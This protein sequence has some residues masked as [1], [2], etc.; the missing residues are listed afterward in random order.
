MLAFVVFHAFMGLRTVV[1]DYTGGGVRTVLT[2]ALYLLAHRP[3]RDGHDRRR[4]RCRVSR[5]HDRPMIRLDH[6]ALIVGAGGAGLWAAA[7]ARQGRAS[8]P[9]S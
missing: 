1:R 8:T 2:M 3:V 6:D 7:R 4:S 9:R 5:R